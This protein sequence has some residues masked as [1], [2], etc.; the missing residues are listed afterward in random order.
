M[1]ITSTFSPNAGVLSVFG[2]ASKNT[3]TTSRDAAGSILIN[4]GAVPSS[5]AWRRSPTPP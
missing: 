1:A 3:I 5:A 4:G 2:D